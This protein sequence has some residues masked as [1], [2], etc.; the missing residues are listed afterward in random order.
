MKSSDVAVSWVCVFAAKDKTQKKKG[1]KFVV[2]KGSTSEGL[3]IICDG[4]S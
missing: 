3:K 1:G 2:E 4:G